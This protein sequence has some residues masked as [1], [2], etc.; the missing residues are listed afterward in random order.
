MIDYSFVNGLWFKIPTF[1]FCLGL[2]IWCAIE[3]ERRTKK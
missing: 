3:D 1:I 2:I